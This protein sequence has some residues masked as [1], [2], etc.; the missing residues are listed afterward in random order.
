MTLRPY[1]PIDAAALAAGARQV[2]SAISARH[3]VALEVIR[4]G[5][6]GPY[7]LEPMVATEFCAIESC[8]KCTP[9]R[10]GSTPGLAIIDRNI[11]SENR[12]ANTVLLEDLCNALKFGR[13]AHW[14]A[15]RPIR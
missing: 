2:T 5:S 9:Y 6:R 12:A 13:R 15:S 7:S 10:V 3:N 8:G 1:I 4:T 14:A 11:R